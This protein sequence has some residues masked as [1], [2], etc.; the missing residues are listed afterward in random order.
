M[1]GI[2]PYLDLFNAVSAFKRTADAPATAEVGLFW[3]IE[4]TYRRNGYAPEAARALIDYLFTVEKLG[5]IIATTGYENLPSQKVMR[6]LGMTVQ[7]LDPAKPP[8][9]FVVGVLENQ[10]GSGP[11]P[12]DQF[13]VGVLENK[14][15]SGPK[16][17]CTIRT[18]QAGE[19]YEARQLIYKVAQPLMEPHLS[20]EEVTTLWNSW[21]AFNDLD[22]VQESYFENGGVFLVVVDGEKIVGTGGFNRYAGKTCELKRIALLPEYQGQGLGYKMT[23]ELIHQAREMGY[24]KMC[25]WT[26]RTR[27][28]RAVDF[29]HRIGF[30]DV[31]HAVADEE[32]LWM[33]LE[34]N[35]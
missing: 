16:S 28:S 27:L 5:R 1:V 23:L 25:L 11:K 22:R 29:F 14:P 12:P 34:I 7:L 10:P 2:V 26:N 15:G 31:P 32:E 19:T 8:D 24:D 13:V 35:A 21:G 6:K 4:P 9:Q 33:E 20:L 3:A 30:V 18:I 17:V